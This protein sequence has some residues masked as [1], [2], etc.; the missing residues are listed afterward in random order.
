M[1]LGFLNFDYGNA[2]SYSSE[3]FR[4]KPPGRYTITFLVK[5]CFYYVEGRRAEF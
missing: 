2:V 1:L 4:S 5:F 3:Q